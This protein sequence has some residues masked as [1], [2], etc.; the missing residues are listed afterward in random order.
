MPGSAKSSRKGLKAEVGAAQR[1]QIAEGRKNGAQQ[2]GK[3]GPAS[4]STVSGGPSRV[5]MVASAKLSWHVARTSCACLQ[6]AAP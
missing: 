1:R 3:I 6:L 2:P 5:S 4:S